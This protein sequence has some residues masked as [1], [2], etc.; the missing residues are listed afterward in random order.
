MYLK[1]LTTTS[2][3]PLKEDS[4]DATVYWRKLRQRLKAEGNKTVTT[5]HG[6]KLRAAALQ[7]RVRTEKAV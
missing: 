3:R 4:V 1:I 6:L 7:K 2:T 5:C